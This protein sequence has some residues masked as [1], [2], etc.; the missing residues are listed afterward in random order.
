MTE[1]PYVGYSLDAMVEINYRRQSLEPPKPQEPALEAIF[2]DMCQVLGIDPIELQSDGRSARD[3]AMAKKIFCY[4]GAT[5][6]TRHHSEIGYLVNIDRSCVH[7]YKRDVEI[8]LKIKRSDFL[9]L[10]GRYIKE[11]KIWQ[12]A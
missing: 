9:V 4:L 12:R 3:K 11:S 6:T 1:Y 2:T 10:W 8:F 5:L 7:T